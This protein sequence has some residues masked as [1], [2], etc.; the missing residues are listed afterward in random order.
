VKIQQVIREI[1]IRQADGV[2]KNWLMRFSVV[3]P[4]VIKAVR[5][6]VCG[7]ARIISKTALYLLKGNDMYG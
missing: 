6:G 3:N 7:L 2:G 1:I 5:L 4:K